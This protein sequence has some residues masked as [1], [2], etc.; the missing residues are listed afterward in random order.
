MDSIPQQDPHGT[1]AADT[2]NSSPL[3][4]REE[5]RLAFLTQPVLPEPEQLK[6][7][8]ISALLALLVEGDWGVTIIRLIAEQVP[9]KK[10]SEIWN[11]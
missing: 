6:L 7:T 3:Q 10:A 4:L 2:P 11:A 9:K 8:H 1:S 5:A